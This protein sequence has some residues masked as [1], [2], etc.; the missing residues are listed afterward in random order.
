MYHSVKNE[1]QQLWTVERYYLRLSQQAVVMTVRWRTLWL[2][3]GALV[4]YIGVVSTAYVLRAVRR[5]GSRGQLMLC[6]CAF[7]LS[8][9]VT[10]LYSPIG[11]SHLIT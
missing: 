8:L 5:H 11:P 10:W 7:L 4:P 2:L 3:L 1:A 6:G 9:F